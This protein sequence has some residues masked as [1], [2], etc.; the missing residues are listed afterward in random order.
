M[1]L[2]TL[3]EYLGAGQRHP[4]YNTYK[5]S[6]KV[7]SMATRKPLGEALL[8]LKTYTDAYA[9]RYPLALEFRVL[10]VTTVFDLTAEQL[11]AGHIEDLDR[12]PQ[13]VEDFK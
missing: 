5:A 1:L 13:R 12:L 9:A 7:I 6:E 2:L 11:E 3:S 8:F 4:E 10:T